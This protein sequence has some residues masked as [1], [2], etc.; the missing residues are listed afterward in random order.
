MT[1]TSTTEYLA[2][3][4]GP[5]GPISAAFFAADLRAALAVVE[6]EGRSWFDGAEDYLDVDPDS[7]TLDSDLEEALD[8]WALVSRAEHDGDWDIYRVEVA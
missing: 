6:A 7:P 1:E 3:Y 2:L 8:G 5:N 4:T